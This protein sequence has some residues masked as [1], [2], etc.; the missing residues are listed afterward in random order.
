MTLKDFIIAAALFGA[1]MPEVAAVT[2]TQAVAQSA[3][4][5]APDA[6][7]PAMDAAP[8]PSPRAM[9]PPA[10]PP[11]GTRPPRSPGLIVLP[12]PLP[13][14][15]PVAPPP[16]GPQRLPPNPGGRPADMFGQGGGEP[17]ISKYVAARAAQKA[18][19]GKLLDVR[20]SKR[21]AP[22]Y[23]VKLRDDSQIRVVVIDARTGQVLGY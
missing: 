23:L 10:P 16:G 20:L 3:T 21:G 11:P 14:L 13:G 15:P 19:P 18:V 5:S 8:A 17:L 1:V 9:R 6:A 4:V 22:V 12:Q 7:R 2:A